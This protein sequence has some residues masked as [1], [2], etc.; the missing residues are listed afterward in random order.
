MCNSYTDNIFVPDETRYFISDVAYR[1]YVNLNND[2]DKKFV[3]GYIYPALFRTKESLDT[4][5]NFLIS[6]E[7]VEY[8]NI[9]RPKLNVLF[10]EKIEYN[11]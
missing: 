3:L 7:Y 9:L 1:V 8:G 11:K 6:Q 10:G 4:F 2:T 5:C